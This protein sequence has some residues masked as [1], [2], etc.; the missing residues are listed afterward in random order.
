MRLFYLKKSTWYYPMHNEKRSNNTFCKLYLV[1]CRFQRLAPLPDL[2]FHPMPAKAINVFKGLVDW[3]CKLGKFSTWT[4][5][6]I[7]FT[8]RHQPS[9]A[10]S[11]W[12]NIYIIN[13]L[14]SPRHLLVMLFKAICSEISL[15]VSISNNLCLPMKP[16]GTAWHLDI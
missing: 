16:E 11:Y 12:K 14:Q 2:D 8:F 5:T 1:S 13:Y 3:N 7:Y 15:T 6:D 10:D 4:W 9:Q